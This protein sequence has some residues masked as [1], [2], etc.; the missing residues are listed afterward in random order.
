MNFL[1]GSAEHVQ[2]ITMAKGI[3]TLVSNIIANIPQLPLSVAYILYN[4]IIT[5]MAIHREW[6][7]FG[8][9]SEPK[10]LR[11]SRPVG[12]QRSTYWLQLPYRFAVPLMGV[13]ATLHY[14]TSQ[15]LFYADLRIYNYPTLPG[16]KDISGLGYSMG[17][18][19]GLAV[20]ALVLV[21]AA[22]AL[23]T[24]KVKTGGIPNAR[25]CSAAIS[26]ACHQSGRD[27]KAHEKKL[28]W[29]SVAGGSSDAAEDVGHCCFTSGD[30]TSLQGGKRY[31]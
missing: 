24:L 20:C 18:L 8:P 9:H 17:A 13:S 14:L 1:A 16:T 12:E 5:N 31:V 15:S 7:S 22:V 26:A 11:T 19:V 29:G 4:R 2:S 6:A 3:N 27:I 21:I 25:F 28:R 30:T 23:G 10:A